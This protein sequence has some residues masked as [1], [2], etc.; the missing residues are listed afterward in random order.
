M[1]GYIYKTT[2]LINGKI[3]IGQHISNKFTSK[4]FGSGIKIKSALKKYGVGNFI[5]ELI[6]ECESI[7]ELNDSEM[8][9]IAEFNST[10]PSIG[11]NIKLGGNNAPWSD[12]VKAKMSASAIGKKKSDETKKKI[13]NAKIG[14]TCAG[15]C[16]LGKIVINDGERNKF[17]Y[18]SDAD[19]FLA[20]G[21]SM[22]PIKKTEEELISYHDK[23]A[24]RI[25]IN[26]DGI[27]KYVK[28]E[29]LQDFL[30]LGWEIGRVGY[31]QERGKRISST[32]S[33]RIRIIRGDEIRYIKEDDLESYIKD[34]FTPSRS[35]YNKKETLG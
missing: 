24:N 16:N 19:Y 22:G 14:N 27:C 13:S 7:K 1:Y 35:I 17:I 30:S 10:D 25:Y 23:Y 31:T 34:G 6:Q 4:Y 15:T 3:Y 29:E 2:N 12:E 32:K 21:Y 11:Y 18:P 8:F 28:H 33:G 9:W 26:K 20:N 5:V